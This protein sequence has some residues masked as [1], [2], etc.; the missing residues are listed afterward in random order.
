M[1]AITIQPGTQICLSALCTHTCRKPFSGTAFNTESLR[2]RVLFPA[3]LG[4]GSLQGGSTLTFHP[5]TE[6]VDPRLPF[7]TM[8]RVKGQQRSLWE[9]LV[10]QQLLYLLFREQLSRT[11][12][13]HL[14]GRLAQH[15]WLGSA[16]SA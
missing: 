12:S 11:Q 6:C 13:P 14:Q 16:W 15:G 10:V 4:M 7:H 9:Q 3:V 5:G 1:C 2:W 8:G